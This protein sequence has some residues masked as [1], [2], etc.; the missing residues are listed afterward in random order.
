ML[1]DYVLALGA[2]EV[3]VSGTTNVWLGA[4]RDEAGQVG[5]TTFLFKWRDLRCL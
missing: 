4:R 5:R 1:I 2:K 3:P